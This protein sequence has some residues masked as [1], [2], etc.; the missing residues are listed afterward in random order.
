MGKKRLFCL[1]TAVLPL[2]L[3]AIL[4]KQNTLAGVGAP[5]VIDAILYDGLVT[6]ELDEA[7][8]IR[9]VTDVPMDVGGWELTD[10][11]ATAVLPPN[12][13]LE[14]GETLWL[15]RNGA[16]FQ[17]QFG[18]L[19][20]FE[21]QETDPN[22]PNMT[23]SWTGLNNS[24]DQLLL[25]DNGDLV[26]CVPFEG[27]YESECGASWSGE[28][29][30]PYSVTG[31]FGAEG[32]ILFRKR[33]EQSGWPLADTNTA[34]DWAQ[35]RLDVVNGRRVWYPG[36]E[37]D[38]F[39][40]PFAVTETAVLTLAVTPDNGYETL[41]NQIAFAQ[42]SIL[43]EALTFENH[44][45]AQAL[46]AAIERGVDVTVLLEGAPSGGI[47]QDQKFSCQLIEAA[48][49]ACWFM[50][51][52]DGQDIFDRYRFMHAKIMLIDG[53]R[54][55]I[56]SENLSPN[57]LPY[58]DKS[59]GTWG[60][61][62]VL[63]VTDAPS[64]IAHLT[65]IF[66]DDFDPDNHVDLFRWQS[67]HDKYGSP[68]PSYEPVQETGG[69]T[70]TVR[71]EQALRLE[72]TFDFE[73]VQSPENSLR[74][75]DGLLGLLN[76]AGVGD[77]I[78]AQQLSER[79]FWGTNANDDPNPRLQAMV[80]A[81]RRGATVR[82][83]LDS[84]FDDG[85]LTSNS[86]TCVYIND[87]ANL[88]GLNLECQLANPTGLGI[89]NKMI[90]AEISGQGFIHV[91][92]LNGSEQSSKGNREI[93]IQ[94]QSNEAF[95]YLAAVF[96]QDWPQFTFLPLILNGVE[97]PV[98]HLLISEVLYNPNGPDDAE[99]IEI[100]NPT[101]TAVNLSNASLSDAI[102]PA[103]FEDL[104]RFPEGTILEAGAVLVVATTAT[105]FRAEFGFDPDFEILA[106]DTAVPTL[107]DDL[108]WGDTGAH[109]QLANQGDE[110]ILRDAQDH[111]ID[112]IVYGDGALEGMIGC[113][114]VAEQNVSL[115]RFPF[116]QD[117]DN[118]PNDFRAWPF[119][120]PG[121]LP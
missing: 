103:D 53:A 34:V 45:I 44:A 58:D 68:L 69:V 110:V 6:G 96:E 35:D 52:D 8:R 5:V 33:D 83:M 10:G 14:S 26:D 109:L 93:A 119:P 86:A 87:L 113:E 7:V 15:A 13:I 62:G 90:L 66:E 63:L 106:T 88:E 11:E 16:A 112:F 19:P 12:I 46:V 72:G 107:T 85:G 116:D 59:D 117:T 111:V 61:R 64:V 108:S 56:S 73:I 114:L 41:V 21:L 94:V 31:V 24:G 18:H 98:Q 76:Q 95:A 22:I 120:N 49:G 55:I 67:N 47:K 23:G 20:D 121:Q 75:S 28:V 4:F 118:C 30:Q 105:G 65:T 9:N 39:F 100:V 92:S 17:K 38:D 40:E 60:R 51:S 115:E 2:T 37:V 91:G 77:T 48:G 89:H 78:L 97:A 1:F 102:N 54:A 71:H 25:I 80:E 84:F 70:Y 27:R 50:I 82:L 81:A 3:L 42:D 74:Q 32:Q 43:I 36:W 57:S 99:F 104:R 79:P 29:V 101:N